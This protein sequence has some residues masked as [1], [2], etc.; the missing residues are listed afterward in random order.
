MSDITLGDPEVSRYHAQLTQTAT[1]YQIQD[2]GSTNGTYIDDDR[3]TGD[4]RALHPGQAVQLGSGVILE[5][6]MI[7]AESGMMATMVDA[8]ADLPPQ[9]PLSSIDPTESSELGDLPP[10]PEFDD[11]YVDAAPPPE[12]IY[13]PEPDYLPSQPYAA[14]A[15]PPASA[16]SPPPPPPPPFIPANGN[17]GGGRGRRRIIILLVVLLILCCCVFLYTGYQ[18][19]GDPLLDLI[20]DALGQRGLTSS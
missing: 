20:L 8:S 9:I 14:Q 11:D 18:Y 6:Q 1:G 15:P 2:M 5:Y 10:L 19:W 13:T 7:G 16:P 17:G 3:L 12:P 4:P